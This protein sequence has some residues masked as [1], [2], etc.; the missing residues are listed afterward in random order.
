MG[1]QPWVCTAFDVRG[2][3]TSTFYPAYGGAA[4]RT[5]TYDYSNPLEVKVTDPVGTIT[6]TVDLLGRTTK[7][8]NALGNETLS[9]HDVA[10]RPITSTLLGQT[11]TNAYLSD[12][13]LDTVSVNGKTLSKNA[14]A[15]DGR[16]TGVFYPA[17]ATGLG[18]GTTGEFGYDT[19][20]RPSSI[21]WKNPAGAVIASEN[22]T[23]LSSGNLRERWYDGNNLNGSSPDFT[24]DG[25]GR[26]TRAIVN[27]EDIGYSFDGGNGCGLAGSAGKNSNR[28]GL[29]SFSSV[30]GL[31][32]RNAEFCYDHADRG[33]DPRDASS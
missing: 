21:T 22:V 7:Y 23:R 18:N 20:L 11:T 5:V 13:L 25:A 24:Y 32:E 9:T 33:A 28:T 3:P 4:A 26:L 31:P 17:G 14:Y 8:K 12:G 10:N 29:A 19:L 6:S 2:R 15:A 1:T 30:N 27:G 16:L